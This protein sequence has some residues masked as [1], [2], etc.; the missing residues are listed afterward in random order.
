[1]GDDHLGAFNLTAKTEMSQYE[2]AQPTLKTLGVQG[3]EAVGESYLK[4][5]HYDSRAKQ[6][7][8]VDLHD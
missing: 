7:G 6:N 8:F 3:G 2:D 1:M 5:Q 4:S